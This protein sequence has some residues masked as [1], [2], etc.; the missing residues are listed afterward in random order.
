MEK[1]T[2]TIVQSGSRKFGSNRYEATPIHRELK[3]F[4]SHHEYVTI[5]FVNIRS[6]TQSW[7]DEVLGKFILEEGRDFL[8]RVNF[9]NCTP[10]VQSILKLVIT[11]RVSGHAN[12]KGKEY[13]PQDGGGLGISKFQHA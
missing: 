1:T 11:D 4:L 6:A 13:L 10:V 8:T 12:Y 5:D 9:K 3:E 7:V 2:F